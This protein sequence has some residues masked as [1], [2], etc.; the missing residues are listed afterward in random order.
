MER[1]VVKRRLKGVTKVREGR[2]Y[3]LRELKEVG[4]DNFKAVKMDIP[5]DKFRKTK[6]QENVKKLGSI[7][8]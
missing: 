5:L 4:L 7:V 8:R 1:A 2:G 3:S 6:H